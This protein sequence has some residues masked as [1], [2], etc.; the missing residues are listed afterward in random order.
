MFRSDRAEGAVPDEG[1]IGRQQPG[2][3][4][5]LGHLQRLFDRYRGQDGGHRAGQQRLAGSRWPREKY[6][7]G[8]TYQ[9]ITLYRLVWCYDSNPK[10]IL[11]P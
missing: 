7:V 9:V 8:T 2:D 4:I 10:A 6:I 5:D 1:G 3:A 11:P